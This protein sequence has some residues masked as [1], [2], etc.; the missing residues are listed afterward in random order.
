MP[1]RRGSTCQLEAYAQSSPDPTHH[2]ADEYSHVGKINKG[3]KSWLAFCKRAKLIRIR[4]LP[5]L[6]NCLSRRISTF[7]SGWIWDRNVCH[8]AFLYIS[9][10]MRAT[11]GALLGSP[12]FSSQGSRMCSMSHSFPQR[13]HD[14][15]LLFPT[16][17]QLSSLFRPL[18]VT[19]SPWRLSLRLI[20]PAALF[21][22]CLPSF[23]SFSSSTQ[24]RREAAGVW[25][26][27]ITMLQ[28][29]GSP[30]AQGSPAASSCHCPWGS[31]AQHWQRCRFPTMRD[32]LTS[33]PTGQQLQVLILASRLSSYGRRVPR[34]SYMCVIGKRW[35]IQEG[36]ITLP[37]V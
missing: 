33:F 15:E 35:F 11:L 3:D 5:T 34:R 19:L 21:P 14:R 37:S 30:R 2:S 17:S 13:G 29:G 24:R 12:T 25:L 22:S 18:S 36:L 1:A 26:P 28:W 7:K 23:T 6:Q 32:F 10:L 20:S 31:S 9:Q 4:S 8:C 16:L 27:A